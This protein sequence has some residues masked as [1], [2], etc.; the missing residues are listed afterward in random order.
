MSTMMITTIL[1]SIRK[2]WG[3]F[4]MGKHEE[5]FNLRVSEAKAIL[6]EKFDYFKDALNTEILTVAEFNNADY[7]GDQ[8]TTQCPTSWNMKH[9][10][11]VIDPKWVHK[12]SVE[13]LA[14]AYGFVVWAVHYIIEIDE[15]DDSFINIISANL[16]YEIDFNGHD[17]FSKSNAWLSDEYSVIKHH[18]QDMNKVRNFIEFENIATMNHREIYDC[19]MLKKYEIYEMFGYEDELEEES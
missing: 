15:D 3:R 16:R 4:D 6:L 11:I 1:I 13:E 5:K 14:Y 7:E 18:R 12:H 2:F 8:A 19:L 17:A 9:N 10:V